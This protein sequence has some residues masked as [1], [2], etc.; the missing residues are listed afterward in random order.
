MRS[1]LRNEEGHFN[2]R[3]HDR[4]AFGASSA[5][6]RYDDGSPVHYGGSTGR[7]TEGLRGSAFFTESPQPPTESYAGRP[8][9]ARRH[10]ELPASPPASV[11]PPLPPTDSAGRSPPAYV[12][13]P[14]EVVLK[15]QQEQDDTQLAYQRYV[16]LEK[17][18]QLALAKRQRK[19][20]EA[21]RFRHSAPVGDLTTARTLH[22]QPDV[23]HPA[24]SLYAPASSFPP[25]AS[26]LGGRA[27]RTG[28]TLPQ[29]TSSSRQTVQEQE[30][31]SREEPPLCAVGGGDREVPS[32]HWPL[33]PPPLVAMEE[34]TAA[35]QRKTSR[36]FAPRATQPLPLDEDS[37]SKEIISRLPVP[38]STNL[39]ESP[40]SAYK[41]TRS[42][43]FMSSRIGIGLELSIRPSYHL[44]TVED[45]AAWLANASLGTIVDVREVDYR[46]GHI[47]GSLHIPASRLP[48]LLP[49]LR[50]A[51]TQPVCFVCINGEVLSRDAAVLFGQSKPLPC[52]LDGG[53]AAWVRRYHADDQLVEDLDRSLWRGIWDAQP[54]ALPS[55]KPLA[56]QQTR[57]T[58][59]SQESV[60]PVPQPPSKVGTTG[61]DEPAPA[62]RKKD[63]FSASLALLDE[64]QG[65]LAIEAPS[66]LAILDAP[67]GTYAV[68]DLRDEDYRGGN[69]RGSYHLPM[70]HFRSRIALHCSTLCSCKWVAFVCM[71]GET[72]S[73][74]AAT[75]FVEKHNELSPHTECPEIYVLA[76]GFAAFA[77]HPAARRWIENF[78]SVF[79]AAVWNA[80]EATDKE[81]GSAP[82]EPASGSTG[83]QPPAETEE[84]PRAER[85]QLLAPDQLAKQMQG[86]TSK[87]TVIIDCR[88][89]RHGPHITGS[90]HIPSTRLGQSDY[91]TS[92]SKAS[93]LVFVCSDGAAESPAAASAFLDRCAS[94]NIP[95]DVTPAV[96]V[97]RGG[98]DAWAAQFWEIPTLTTASG[99]VA[100]KHPSQLPGERDWPMERRKLVELE[101]TRRSDLVNVES[102]ART[103]ELRERE[104]VQRRLAAERQE[105][106][107]RQEELERTAR[108]E[109]A[110]GNTAS[111]TTSNRNV[112]SP[113]EVDS[114]LERLQARFQDLETKLLRLK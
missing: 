114:E 53:F 15:R 104:L 55:P 98:N 73:P 95:G 94:L 87:H 83:E 72:A 12:Y 3:Y 7:S 47:P 19:Y 26:A 71:N 2:L 96:Y 69:I 66:L 68:V 64:P 103:H 65:G 18:R 102:G 17:E 10:R 24:P 100:T 62:V 97:L 77:K 76:G 86:S 56:P 108:L 34:A 48:T 67:Q 45:A 25:R 21:Q 51:V 57:H 90:F 81:Y 84:V 9:E 75:L 44:V 110:K 105:L 23:P 112:S 61:I 85:I 5:S 106:R 82:D 88:N 13:I 58:A 80:A 111:N 49:A 6:V 30:L 60:G 40:P 32:P 11:S 42:A 74:E 38:G 107:E 37:H 46:G 29:D 63:V 70:D 39:E 4:L 54:A 35:L 113:S 91:H 8:C 78:D 22:F 36:K 43:S 33:P 16:V 92:L 41:S 89:T 99:E 79:W 1:R 109:E 59:I 27:P 20:D 52:I 50:D 14:A 31:P 28:A 93:A 101:H